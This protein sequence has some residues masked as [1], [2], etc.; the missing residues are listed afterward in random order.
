MGL[1]D[2]IIQLRAQGYPDDQIIDALKQQGI[3]PREISDA[4][5]QAQIKNAVAGEQEMSA[6]E[7]QNVQN[8]YSDQQT[9]QAPQPTQQNYPEQQ[10]QYY[11]EN[12]YGQQGGTQNGGDY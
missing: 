4:I 8:N 3:N 5:A 9:M 2:Q 11:G 6:E 1:I 10:Q 7:Y 12:Q